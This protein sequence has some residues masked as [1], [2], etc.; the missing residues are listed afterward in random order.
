MRVVEDYDY[1]PPHLR[2]PRVYTLAELEQLAREYLTTI[3]LTDTLTPE[4]V[5]SSLIHWL[6]KRER[7]VKG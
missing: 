2:P 3:P 5:L 4:L 7:E 6:K 1:V